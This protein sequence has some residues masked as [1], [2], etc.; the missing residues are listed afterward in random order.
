MEEAEEA[1][2]EEALE[3]EVDQDQ[4]HALAKL[5]QQLLEEVRI[6]R[7]AK[8]MERAKKEVKMVNQAKIERNS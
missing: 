6:T 4:D 7:M 3:A 2:V 8:I 5:I 1:V